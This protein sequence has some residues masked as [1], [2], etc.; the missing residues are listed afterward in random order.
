MAGEEDYGSPSCFKTVAE[1]SGD[2]VAERWAARFKPRGIV[3]GVK[4]SGRVFQQARTERAVLCATKDGGT[5]LSNRAPSCTGCAN[6]SVAADTV[7]RASLNVELIFSPSQRGKVVG[8]DQLLAAEGAHTC[9]Q[10]HKE[11][12]RC[13]RSMPLF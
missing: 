11:A 7:R 1:I 5:L 13:V 12:Q 3:V 8:K 2:Q 9:P 4:V 10:V 6:V